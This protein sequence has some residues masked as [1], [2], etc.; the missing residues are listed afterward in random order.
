MITLLMD[1][2]KYRSATKKL[3]EKN[4]TESSQMWKMK[5]KY[6]KNTYIRKNN[7]ADAEFLDEYFRQMEFTSDSFFLW[8]FRYSVA[9][10]NRILMKIW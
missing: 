2:I 3:N 4:H 6:Q 5:S 9:F 7:I 10:G 8:H 1:R